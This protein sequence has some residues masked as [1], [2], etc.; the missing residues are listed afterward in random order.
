[1]DDQ[2]SKT[3]EQE[4]SD[5]FSSESE[6][7]ALIVCFPSSLLGPQTVQSRLIPS[8]MAVSSRLSESDV[9]LIFTTGLVNTIR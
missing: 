2:A 3:K 4:P 1:M 9:C 8:T 7:S 6:K 5:N